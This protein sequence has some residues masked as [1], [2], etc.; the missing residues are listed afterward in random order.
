MK[1]CP[2]IVRVVFLLAPIVLQNLSTENCL[3]QERYAFVVGVEDYSPEFLKRL[4]FPEDDAIEMSKR[5]EALGY[6]VIRMTGEEDNPDYKPS[7]RETILKALD[8]R[9]KGIEARDTLLI[10]MSGHGIQ[11]SDE[12]KL[13]TG[14]RETYFCPEKASTSP[15]SY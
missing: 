5:L 2:G 15:R 7:D 6:Q 13:S 14:S 8:G 9:L 4:E 10:A 3:A 12:E 11:F 1:Y